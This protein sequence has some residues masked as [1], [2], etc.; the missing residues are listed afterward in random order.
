MI[1]LR[2]K[3]ASRPNKLFSRRK[4]EA[5]HTIKYYDKTPGN[6]SVQLH[7]VFSVNQCFQATLILNIIESYPLCAV[8][9]DGSCLKNERGLGRRLGGRGLS[10][11][12]SQE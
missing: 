5:Y 10:F 7:A 4:L 2:S 11:Y 9:L 1:L 12:Y 8:P 3:S 6:P